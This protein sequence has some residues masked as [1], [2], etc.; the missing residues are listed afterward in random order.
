MSTFK[1]HV[2]QIPK[3]KIA[4][5]WSKVEIKGADECWEWTAYRT[6]FGYGRLGWMGRIVLAHRVA[7]SIEHEADPGEWCVLHN[8]DNPS[9][10]NPAHLRLGTVTENNLEKISKGRGRAVKGEEHGQAKYTEAD[11]LAVRRARLT[12]IGYKRIARL[13]GFSLGFTSSVINKGKWAHVQLTN[14]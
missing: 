5:F 3:W 10:C 6:K 14:S 9:C 12:G 2:E 7:Y 4:G 13:F 1:I 11:V 8:C